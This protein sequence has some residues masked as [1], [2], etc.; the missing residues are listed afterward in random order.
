[1]LP[2]AL[3]RPARHASE[4]AKNLRT[5]ALILQSWHD[6]CNVVAV[7]ISVWQDSVRLNVQVAA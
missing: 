5:T 6:S 1:M 7:D 3:G 2:L 4:V